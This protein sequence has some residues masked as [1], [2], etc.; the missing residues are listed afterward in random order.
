MHGWAYKSG[1]K[2]GKQ[3][4][5]CR[6]RKISSRQKDEESLITTMIGGRSYRY[7]VRPE[8]KEELQQRIAEFRYQQVEEYRDAREEA[9]VTNQGSQ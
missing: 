1:R 6:E 3:I 2:R 7:R 5:A 8:K 9:F 4:W